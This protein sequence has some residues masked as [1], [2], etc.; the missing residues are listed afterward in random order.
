MGATGKDDEAVVDLRGGHPRV[1]GTFACPNCGASEF[2]TVND[3]DD[4]N[5]LCLSCGL[6]WHVELGYVSRVDPVTCPG[7]D[8]HDECLAREWGRRLVERAVTRS[9]DNPVR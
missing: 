5:F 6:C 9:G 7:C 4:V 8:R 2:E 3:G 1:A